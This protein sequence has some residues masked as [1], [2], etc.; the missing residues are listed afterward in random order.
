[1]EC[2]V[3]QSAKN[4]NVESKF[5]MILFGIFISVIIIL[6]LLLILYF[7]LFSKNGVAT[8]PA[9]FGQFGD[10]IG[11]LMNPLI[12]GFAL[13][14]LLITYRSQS[15]EL[16]NSNEMLNKSNRV[17]EQQNFENTF[18][19]WLTSYKKT[20]DGL[21]ATKSRFPSSD[22]SVEYCY[23]VDALEE[24]FLILHDNVLHID[25]KIRREIDGSEFAP[26]ELEMQRETGEYWKRVYLKAVFDDIEKILII[27]KL[28]PIVNGFFNLLKKVDESEPHLRN[29]Y[30]PF[31]LGQLSEI[32]LSV[33]FVYGLNQEYEIINRV[34]T[35]VGLFSSIKGYYLTR[36][37]LL[38]NLYS[39]SVFIRF[40]STNNPT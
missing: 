3:S 7:S 15:Q 30:V 2:R 29:E 10:Y 35:S 23:G 14:V 24:Y 4:D 17:L 9:S 36:F 5:M 19:A 12:S 38:K 39:D 6:G 33:F 20:L 1:M 18:F 27:E 34:G 37:E 22:K 32:E 28:N 16:R 13:F 21:S 8:D 11:G 26:G 25:R 31:L 40:N